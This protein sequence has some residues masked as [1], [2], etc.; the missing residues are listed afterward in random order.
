MAAVAGVAAAATL[1]AWWHGRT[2]SAPR[3]PGPNG[4]LLLGGRASGTQEVYRLAYTANSWYTAGPL[5]IGGSKA[6]TS[7]VSVRVAGLM[8]SQVLSAGREGGIVRIRV[9]APEVSFRMDDRD[10]AEADG[11]LRGILSEGVFARIRPNGEVEAFHMRDREDALGRTTVA[12]LLSRLQ[13]VRAGS[14]NRWTVVEQDPGGTVHADYSMERP[15]AGMLRVRKSRVS[16]TPVRT[17]S[18]TDDF[19]LETRTLP[20]GALIAEI[21]RAT[22]RLLKL[23]GDQSLEVLLQGRLLSRT[24]E[25]LE[26][27]RVPGAVDRNLDGASLR[28]DW[29]RVQTTPRLRIL[30][31]P[32]WH[33]ERVEM[34]RTILHGATPDSVLSMLSRVGAEAGDAP[35]PGQVIRSLE[36]LLV[37]D[38]GQARRLGEM[39]RG[40]EGRR[41]EVIVT[42]L[43]KAGTPES[44]HVLCE[45]ARRAG[46]P[47]ELGAV[48]HALALVVEPTSE[49]L[50]LLKGLTRQPDH[51]IA[52][53]ARLALGVIAR[54]FARVDAR[55][56]DELVSWLV[57]GMDGRDR[58]ALR[59]Q[60]LALGNAGSDRGLPWIVRYSGDE[61]PRIRRAAVAAL[62]FYD[63]ASAESVLTR[64]LRPEEDLEVRRQAAD[65]AANLSCRSA[66]YHALWG[67][68]GNDP[69]ARMRLIALE[70][71][72]HCQERLRLDL[73]RLEMVAKEDTV[74]DVR[75]KAAAL[76]RT[77]APN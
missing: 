62:R 76:L 74:E 18:P 34:A 16:L 55:A 66:V 29:A 2:E 69:S 64:A 19:E 33:A 67:L 41:R 44:Q 31:M 30:E 36:G 14:G 47:A 68:V 56:A 77:M 25:H 7:R 26:V 37:V 9:S 32:D 46:D 15:R 38:R 40:A 57:S 5:P 28:S 11:I 54:R 6:E 24:E 75:A 60:I 42:S 71:L 27:T 50:M 22:G 61:D 51:Q 43:G 17:G 20:D 45:Q 10:E 59:A 3:E 1:A 58:D 63:N 73:G 65:V 52:W 21:E 12:T 48:I 35:N 53:G 72:G 39:L 13:L 8:H 70:S 4:L 49:T 23:G